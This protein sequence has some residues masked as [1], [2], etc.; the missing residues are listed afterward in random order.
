MPKSPGTIPPVRSRLNNHL[1]GF[2]SV[3]SAMTWL[4]V[5]ALLSLAETTLR[6]VDQG[7]P[8][9][10]TTSELRTALFIL[11]VVA[12]LGEEVVFRWLPRLLFTKRPAWV[13]LAL[14]VSSLMWMAPHYLQASNRHDIWS[15][16]TDLVLAVIVIR[17]CLDRRW[18]IWILAFPAHAAYNFWSLSQGWVAWELG[19]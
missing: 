18:P 4:L 16:P 2:A 17:L 14:V 6:W 1:K 10:V 13:P 8:P 15:V 12:P 5:L 19:L 11:I 9:R 7:H 3:P